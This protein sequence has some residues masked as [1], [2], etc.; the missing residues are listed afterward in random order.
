MPSK[1]WIRTSSLLLAVVLALSPPLAHAQSK[2]DL[3]KQAQAAESK[4]D[5]EG[6]ANAYCELAKM[7]TGTYG[8]KCRIYS[9][10]VSKEREND[11]NRIKEGKAALSSGDFD[12]AKQKFAAVKLTENKN[13]ASDY[14]SNKI[15]QAEKAAATAAAAA[16]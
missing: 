9:N 1:S 5:I 13:V 2:D 14:L 12:T 7:D 6:A 10:Q 15:P 3:L 16:Q 4:A 8:S 11:A